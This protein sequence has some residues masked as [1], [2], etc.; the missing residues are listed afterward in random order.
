LLTGLVQ[1]PAILVLGRDILMEILASAASGDLTDIDALIDRFTTVTAHPLMTLIS[2][3]TFAVLIAC[4]CF[5]CRCVEKRRLA[6]LG[7]RK[8]RAWRESLAGFAA[9]AGLFGAAVLLCVLTGTLTLREPSS[10]G[11]PGWVALFLLGFL[12]QGLAEE[13]LC[14]GFLLVSLARRQPLPVAVLVSS[15]AFAAMHGLN[16]GVTPLAL[17]NLALYGAFA[18]LYL[19]KRGDIWGIAAFHAAWN[20]VQGNVFGIHVSGMA[21][22]PSL[23]SFTPSGKGTWINGG[24]FGLEGGLAVTLVCAAGALILLLTKSREPGGQSADHP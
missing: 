7:F 2:L 9:G 6:T 18:A 24:G 8:R 17:L 22:M 11:A 10:D 21:Q 23:L 12:I 3:L 16:Q 14:R 13:V 15:L 1:L 4:V 5:Y 20:F 19:L